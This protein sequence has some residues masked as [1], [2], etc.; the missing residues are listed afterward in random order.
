MSDSFEPEIR[1]SGGGSRRPGAARASE[2]DQTAEGGGSARSF[3]RGEVLALGALGFILL[4]TV[5]WWALALWPVAG[6]TPEWLARTRAVC[7]NATES[8]LPDASGWLLL[9][10]EPLGMAGVLAVVWKESLTS[11]LARLARS[12]PGRSALVLIGVL[13]LVGLFATAA[14]VVHATERSSVRLV[15]GDQPPAS[16]PR[17]ERPAPATELVDQTGARFDL[18]GMR[19]RP[20]FVTFAFGH[21]ETICPLVVRNALEARRRLQP[22]AGEARPAVVVVT[23]DPWRDRP[24][25]LPHLARK[26]GLTDEDR[27]LSGSVTE[28]EAAL[29]AWEVPRRRD[30]RTGDIA[31]PAL[32]YLVDGDGRI[33]FASRGDVATLMALAERL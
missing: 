28:V 1:P 19:G 3:E 29:D 21:C 11:G 26:W 9:I 17:L 5:A 33:A 7:F 8:G 12:I 22:A 20:V 25:R 2:T 18:A 31:H 6:E 15:R 13:A 14:R 27:V 23:L 16:Y 32:V 10:G 30:R 4:V 24:G